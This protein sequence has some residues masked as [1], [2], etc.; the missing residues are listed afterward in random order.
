MKQLIVK[1]LKLLGLYE[2]SESPAYIKEKFI[3]LNDS[4]K[5]DL[6]KAVT[7]YLSADANAEDYAHTF[8]SHSFGRLNNFRKRHIYFLDK[9][10]SL[11][12][13]KVL[14][15]GCGT[16]SSS[17]ALAEQ[18]A[19]VYGLDVDDTSLILAKERIA[20]YKLDNQIELKLGNATELDKIYQEDYFDVVIFFASIEHMTYEERVLALAAA[21]KVLKKGGALCI[22]GTPNRLW[23]FDSHT[24]MLPFYYWLP[25][26][27]AF[28]YTR[29]SQRQHF[30]EL[31]KRDYQ[32]TQEEFARWGRGVSY[33]ELE[34]AIKPVSELKVLGDL[35]SF[36]RPKTFLQQFSYKRTDDFKY[37]QVLSNQG[38]K[39]LHMGFYEYYLDIAIQKN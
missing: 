5:A 3:S 22:L 24:S 31:Y 9:M 20:L 13:K 32:Q 37:K 12:G 34:L 17:I 11:K 38:P 36:E 35:H 8:N 1:L 18:G 23:M 27:I 15:I 33:H 29:F 2:I 26:E 25:D 7:K 19:Y 10:A 28:Q 14:E 16:A 39:G 21:W 6:E 4:A 30:K